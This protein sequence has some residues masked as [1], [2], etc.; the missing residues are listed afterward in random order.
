VRGEIRNTGTTTGG[1]LDVICSTV[2][3]EGG[4][5]E[6]GQDWAT[7]STTLKTIPAAST[8]PLCAIRLRNTFGSYNHNRMIVRIGN[9]NVFSDGENI[10]WRLV[11]LANSASITANT[12]AWSNAN[13]NSGVQSNFDIISFTGGEEIDNGF[14]SASTQGSQKVGGS[15]PSNLPSAAKKNYIVQNFQS[16]DSEIFLVYATNLGTQPTNVGIGLQW[17]EIY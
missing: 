11:K 16:T 6:A 2:M 5:V 15:P 4:Y 9:L 1:N 13:N 14:I 3:S 7:A 10:L 17:R 12:I 8:V